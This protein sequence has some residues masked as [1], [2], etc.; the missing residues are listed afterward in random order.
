MKEHLLTLFLAFTTGITLF[1]S[2]WIHASIAVPVFDANDLLFEHQ[3]TR[4][5]LVIT[6]NAYDDFTL[7]FLN[8][9][10]N[11]FSQVGTAYGQPTAHES[12]SLISLP[13]DHHVP[14]TTHVLLSTHPK[15][16]HMIVIESGSQIAHGAHGKE[17]TRTDT[18][19]FMVASTDLTGEDVL[20]LGLD[21]QGA[22]L[23]EIEIP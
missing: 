13:A 10:I 19:A 14:F 11:G 20:I 16:H 17:T 1:I 7:S 21:Q 9:N 18:T 6:F 15:L 12:I 8:R 2:S 3:T 23:V 22:I 4:G 5:H